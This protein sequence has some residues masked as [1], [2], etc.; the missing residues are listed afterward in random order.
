MFLPVRHGIP[1]AMH[2][3]GSPCAVLA[4]LWHGEG[5]REKASAEEDEDSS[6]DI[7]GLKYFDELVPLL[8][9]L[10]DVGTER[11]RAGNRQLHMDQY[12]MLV[13]LFLFNPIVTS[14]RAIQQASEL[15]KVQKKLGCPRTSLGSLSEATDVFEPERLQEVIAELAGQLKP[16]CQDQRL[17]DV[18]HLLTLV[19]GTVVKTLSRM[20][21][22][23]YLTSPGD[24][25]RL[26]AWRLH[27]HF[28]VER[29]IPT[30]IDV[31]GGLNVGEQDEHHVLQQHLQPDRCYV[32]DRGFAKFALFNAIHAVQSSYVCRLP[33]DNS[34]YQVLEQ[35]PLSPEAQEAEFRAI[36]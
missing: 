14:L 7:Q 31:T 2:D 5:F 12:C 8:E 27:T 18:Q 34:S 16:I 4:G 28:E 25:R 20:V 19:D 22:A 21:Q 23:A 26:Y 33:R 11:D 9:R 17:Q 3:N 24:G 32:M 29:H 15:E 35:R 6:R 30:R 10:H 36:A 1:P 13:L